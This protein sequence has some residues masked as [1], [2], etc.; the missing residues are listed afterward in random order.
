MKTI[1]Y[2]I[3]YWH[4]VNKLIRVTLIIVHYLRITKLKIPPSGKISV[5][6]PEG[7]RVIIET[8]QTSYLTNV[9]CWKGVFAFE[10]SRI[11]YD[12]IREMSVFIDIGANIGFY[13][14]L[15]VKASENIKVYAIEPATGPFIFLQKNIELNK[16]NARVNSYKIALSD[17]ISSIDFYEH[18]NPKYRYLN[19]NLGGISSEVNTTQSNNLI[20]TKVDSTTLDY[21][22]KN[23]LKEAVDLIKIDTEGTESRILEN[24]CEILEKIRP[25]IICETLYNKIEFKLDFLMKNHDYLFFNYMDN[26]LVKVDT[27]IRDEDNGVRDCFFVPKEKEYLITKYL[28]REW[29]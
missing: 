19:Y 17:T 1:F 15:A 23:N 5:S 25:I 9:I 3:I 24:A 27:I 4:P 28:K 22:A 21:F 11:F 14:L 16:E 6:L 26:R 18:K 29:A 12:L 2:K 8:N 10:Y 13:S 7:K 20:K